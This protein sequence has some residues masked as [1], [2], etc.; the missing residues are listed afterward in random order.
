MA[1]SER[2]LIDPDDD[3][4]R[5]LALPDGQRRAL[6]GS[7][8]GRLWGGKAAVVWW[9]DP[10]GRRHVLIR[11][12]ETSD[13]DETRPPLA[14]LYP[15]RLFARRAGGVTAW[16]AACACGAV[17]T[18][19]SLGWMGNCCG[20]CH[21]RREDRAA[22]PPQRPTRLRCPGGDG[23]C[24]LFTPDG[25]SLAASAGHSVWLWPAGG[26][27]G[28]E[29]FRDDR[30]RIQGLAFAEGGTTALWDSANHIVFVSDPDGWE[31]L[32]Y[33]GQ[34]DPP[35]AFDAGEPLTL[36][37]GGDAPVVWWRPE[38]GWREAGPLTPGVS[39][40]AVGPSGVALGGE[41]WVA[42]HDRAEPHADRT[43]TLPGTADDVDF[44]AWLPD[45]KAALAVTAPLN[46]GDLLERRQRQAFLVHTGE[47]PQA[48]RVGQLPLAA[49]LALSPDGRYL[50]GP[51]FGG[52]YSSA[53][54]VFWEVPSCH[55]VARLWADPDWLISDLAFS[56]DGQ[57]LATVSRSGV[58]Q[59]W[60]W[61]R[62][63]EA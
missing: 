14:S 37:V 5:A 43:I 16:L 51:A 21:D 7:P 47:R 50:A 22:A 13:A 11:D 31:Q 52:A 38:A 41:G 1:R 34:T 24:V 26:G 61:R 12:G 59:L 39:A 15:E 3:A 17:G 29:I 44:L 48:E 33:D 62:L 35:L 49:A 42:L 46:A 58:V 19:E 57:T 10:A 28:R 9:S 18:P 2:R 45:G 25:A 54:V 60:P 23:W 36:F 30:T 32:P 8:E 40:L 55:E 56:P 63:L 53:E 4:L 27:P 20:P 6:L